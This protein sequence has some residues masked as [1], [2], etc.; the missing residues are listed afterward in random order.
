MIDR[1]PAI[2]CYKCVEQALGRSNGYPQ[3]CERKQLNTLTFLQYETPLSNLKNAIG[4]GE[5]LNVGFTLQCYQCRICYNED[6]NECHTVTY[7]RPTESLNVDFI[8]LCYQD[9]LYS[10]IFPAQTKIYR[11][12]ISVVI[13]HTPFC[14]S[15]AIS[16]FP[17][18]ALICM[19]FTL[20]DPRTA[21]G[22]TCRSAGV[23]TM[24]STLSNPNI[25][26]SP[27][28]CGKQA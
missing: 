11:T 2:V 27:V 7:L 14:L 16:L 10:N 23:N 20:P 19:R 28:R 26:S 17:F 13:H 5:M 21:A 18:L 6:P 25:Y 9:M 12:Y 24:T 1:F 8:F 15:S 3:G 22:V 4:S